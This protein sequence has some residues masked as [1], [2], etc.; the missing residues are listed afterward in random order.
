MESI[1]K[2]R[3]ISKLNRTHLKSNII[4]KCGLIMNCYVCICIGCGL[5][6]SYSYYNSKNK[7]LQNIGKYKSLI[8]GFSIWFVIPSITI[9]YITKIKIQKLFVSYE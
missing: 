6:G 5:Y 9:L 8:L 2:S 7:F 4:S 3:R 1:Y